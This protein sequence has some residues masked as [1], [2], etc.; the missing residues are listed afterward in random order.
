MYGGGANQQGGT[1]GYGNSGGAEGSY[2]GNTG[3]GYGN[4]GG[5]GYGGNGGNG[6]RQPVVCY[7]CGK[8]GHYSRDCWTKKGRSEDN[9]IEE[10]RQHFRQVIQEKREAEERK[11]DEEQRRIQEENEK[12]REHDLIRR[13]EEMRLKLEAGLEEKWPMQTRQAEEAVAA[14]KAKAEE[15]KAKAEE[16]K[17]KA[18]EAWARAEGAIM[19]SATKMRTPAGSSKKRTRM[20][21]S[22]S[23]SGTEEEETRTIAE[24]SRVKSGKT[25]DAKYRTNKKRPRVIL[26][27]TEP[28]EETSDTS[29]SETTDSDEK[30]RKVIEM[31]K[32]KRKRKKARKEMKGKGK[33]KR[34]ATPTRNGTTAERGE[35]SK[36]NQRNKCNFENCDDVLRNA[37]DIGAD[38]QEER[39]NRAEYHSPIP[40][41]GVRF[42]VPS[43][44]GETDGEKPKTPMEKGYK[45]LAAK[46]S[47]EGIIDYCLSTQKILSSKKAF[48]LRKICQKKGIRYT[49]KPEIIDVLAREQVML[50]YEGFEEPEDGGDDSEQATVRLGEDVLTQDRKGKTRETRS[51][52]KSAPTRVCQCRGS[53]LPTKEGHVSTRFSD[54]NDVPDFVRNAKNV[55]RHESMMEDGPVVQAILEA[56]NHLK[57]RIEDVKLPEG[58]FL[59]G[60][61]KSEENGAWEDTTV[62]QWAK[63]FQGMVLAPID[64]NQGDTAVACPLLYRHAFGKTF[65]WNLDYKGVGGDE[66]G[67]LAQARKDYE[68]AEVNKVEGWKVDGR[69]GRA[70]VIPKD[71]DLMRWRPIAPTTGDPAGQA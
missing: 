30:F 56:T 22:G 62:A 25:L 61:S 37:N 40:S 14:A 20:L 47:R 42:G 66:K 44:H 71:K 59:C 33:R 21:M 17:A 52:V 57:S 41:V 69:I 19:R 29:D 9:E 64:C 11:H 65:V 23:G 67:L 43:N 2:N 7:T 54:L 32:M 4:N 38:F 70:Y 55:T 26:S 8:S 34:E 46:C 13:T 6:G 10:M 60:N 28:E 51:S 50:A 58:G 24:G 3:G 35:C 63:R 36:P 16:A 49:K 12:R 27:S 68:K 18:E 31:L 48:L 15:A 5:G 53:G 39:T 45:G 1:G